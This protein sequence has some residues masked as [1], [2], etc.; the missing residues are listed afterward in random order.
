M[1]GPFSLFSRLPQRQYMDAPFHFWMA[2]FHF[3]SFH[4]LFISV[5]EKA[6]ETGRKASESFKASMPIEFDD[7]LPRYNYTLR[8]QLQV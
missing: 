7:I 3:F 8:P 2:P 5:L 4:F 1:D 6:Y